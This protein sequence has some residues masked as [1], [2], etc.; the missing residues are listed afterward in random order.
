MA[1][2]PAISTAARNLVKRG[3]FAVPAS[4]LAG[5]ALVMLPL[6]YLGWMA[7]DGEAGAFSAVAA[8]VLPRT[9]RDTA[10]L[11][12]GTAL[13]AG[14][15]GTVTGWLIAAYRFPGRSLFA[16]L[17]LLPLAFPA[18]IAAYVYV[19]LLDFYGPVQAAWRALTGSSPL[20]GWLPGMRSLPGAIFVFSIVTYPYVHAAAR[21]VFQSQG[22]SLVDAAQMLGA[23]RMAAFWRVALPMARPAIAASLALVLLETLNDIGASEYLGIA[24]PARAVYAAW[25]QRGDLGTAAKLACLTL[26]FI[27]VLMLIER[28]ARGRAQF[29]NPLRRPRALEP[30]ALPRGKAAAAALCCALPALLGF[31]L[32]VLHL[33]AEVMQRGTAGPALQ[34]LGQAA[35]GTFAAALPATVFCLAFGA[36]IVLAARHSKTLLTQA[37]LR[38]AGL[39]YAVPGLILAIGLLPLY[40]LIDQTLNALAMAAF[41]WRPGLILSGSVLALSLAYVIRFL[42][43]AIGQLEAGLTQRSGN[44]DAAARL[45]GASPREVSRRVLLPLLKPAAAAAGL[46]IFV[47]CVKE[48]PA[49][50]LL[51]P[52]NFETLS[53][54]VYGHAVRG[55]YED[56][57]LAALLIVAIGVLP[58]IQ[59]GRMAD[60][61][62]KI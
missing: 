19:D 18:Y 4:V 25:A 26:A 45:L 17:L 8:A 46:A 5:A 27:I 58:V 36:A 11:L 60:R 48:L 59:L 39:G 1:V 13:L 51:R 12:A 16:G 31:A 7:F 32:P 43:I 42:T 49:T 61:G 40:G 47:D 55:S 9:L 37:G 50:L 15:T 56:G 41:G 29:A 57:A 10:L 2:S 6:A 52:L 54:A 3:G 35:L 22:A 34:S 62:V 14:V 30:A 53:T 23:R 21:I 20:P 33:A 44:L 24:T 38:A 28:A